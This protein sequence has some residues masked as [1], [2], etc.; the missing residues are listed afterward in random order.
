M[1]VIVDKER[2]SNYF[3]S[4]I[5]NWAKGGGVMVV[6]PFSTEVRCKGCNNELLVVGVEDSHVNLSTGSGNVV[7]FNV[8]RKGTVLTTQGNKRDY[9]FN[10]VCPI[11][12]LK[13]LYHQLES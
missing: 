6:V 4:S 9:E 2:L 5:I 8:E 13:E 10:I 11:C 3:L 7:A 12:N 1:S